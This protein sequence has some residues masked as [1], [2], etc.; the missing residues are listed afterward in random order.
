MWL[1]VFLL[2]LVQFALALASLVNCVLT[3]LV[4]G[5]HCVLTVLGPLSF[6]GLWVCVPEMGEAAGAVPCLSVRVLDLHTNA[7]HRP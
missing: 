3:V 2:L 6:V 5:E 7:V 4:R 1:G